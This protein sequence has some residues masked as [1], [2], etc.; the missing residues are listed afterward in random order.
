MPYEEIHHQL[1]KR[2]WEISDSNKMVEVNVVFADGLALLRAKISAGTVTT[3]Y[4]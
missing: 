4:L 3:R 1:K 2:L